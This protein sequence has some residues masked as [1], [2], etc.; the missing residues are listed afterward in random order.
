MIANTI[1]AGSKTLRTT[2][3]ALSHLIFLI[4]KECLRLALCTHRLILEDQ[5]M[6]PSK[7][8]I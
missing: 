1:L 3:M 7:E 4:V 8:S 5:Y 2:H 6:F